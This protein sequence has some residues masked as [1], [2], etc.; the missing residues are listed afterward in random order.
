MQD[1]Q[2]EKEIRKVCENIKKI[3]TMKGYSQQNMA[4]ELNMTQR[5][6]G[7]IENGETDLTLYMLYKICH[8]LGVD[9]SVVLNLKENII[10]HNVNQQNG[11]GYVTFYNASEINHLQ[12]LYERLLKE[13]DAVI[14]EKNKNIEML[15]KLVNKNGG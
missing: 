15:S 14:E 4:D 5:N 10:L 9:I 2:I 1:K 7:R 3:R 12:D 11:G 6:Y 8:A 13:K